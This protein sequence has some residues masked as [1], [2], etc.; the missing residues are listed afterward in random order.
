MGV[1]PALPPY[2]HLDAEAVQCI[3]QASVRYQV[4]E[5]LLHA[6]LLKENGR[7]GKCSK[8]RNGTFDCG[9]AQINTTWFEHFARYGIRP[10][11]LVSNSCINIQAG[12]YVLKDN[13][14]KKADWFKAIVSYN[15]GPYRWTPERYAIGYKY[16]KDV[17][18]HWWRLHNWV[19]ANSPQLQS[20]PATSADTPTAANE[21]I[22][23][24]PKGE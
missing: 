7:T 8:N 17:I 10:E 18:T 23:S 19:V 5:L 1:T 13:Y 14:N 9:F 6:V 22:E 21:I 12:A 15:I 16:A 3:A 2:A 4:P 24:S 20:G 11:H